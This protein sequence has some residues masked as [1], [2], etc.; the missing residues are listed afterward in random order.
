MITSCSRRR[1]IT[2][3]YYFPDERYEGCISIGVLAH[4]LDWLSRLDC[5]TTKRVPMPK[6]GGF[7]KISSRAFFRRIGRCSH[8]LGCRANRA[9]KVSLGGG[10]R[11]RYLRIYWSTSYPSTA[12]HHSILSIQQHTESSMIFHI[13]F[14]NDIYIE[15][16]MYRLCFT[17]PNHPMPSLNDL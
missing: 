15:V 13:Y 12:R 17:P 2:S 10:P 3:I 9:W 7:R 11:L 6:K 14:Q 5:S 16:Y 1:N 4:P 8:P